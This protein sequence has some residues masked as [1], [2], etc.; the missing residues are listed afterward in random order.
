MHHFLEWKT[1]AW[2]S[3]P[4]LLIE[5]RQNSIGFFRVLDWTREG[6]PSFYEPTSWRKN[7][8]PFTIPV[9]I[10][11]GNTNGFSFHLQI[12]SIIVHFPQ[13]LLCCLV[14]R[15]IQA[16]DDVDF[17][18]SE[19]VTDFSSS[20]ATFVS[21]G[22][23]KYFGLSC[24][25][26]NFRTSIGLIQLLLLY[27]VEFVSLREPGGGK[28]ER[29]LRTQL[30]H[31]EDCEGVEDTLFVT[32]PAVPGEGGHGRMPSE[33]CMAFVVEADGVPAGDI[34]LHLWGVLCLA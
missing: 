27:C 25:A 28:A 32:I 23:S 20:A 14:F 22:F 18:I 29:G 30:G 1:A 34:R 24:S 6:R 26:R 10:P 31:I 15:N 16:L 19:L 9:S 2:G 3:Q 21:K 7:L 33:F 5:M 8:I 13:P 12:F 11:N 4:H 17:S